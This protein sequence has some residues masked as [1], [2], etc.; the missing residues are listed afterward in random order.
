MRMT[1]Y[2]FS[3]ASKTRLNELHPDLQ[4]VMNETLEIMDITIAVGF[5]DKA[6]Q[7]AAYASGNSKVQWPNGKHN[8]KP[9]L[10]V[11]VYP[12]VFGIKALMGTEAQITQIMSMF[13]CSKL[14]ANDYVL[15]ELYAMQRI[16]KGIARKHNIK[17]LWGGDWDNDGNIYDNGFNDLGHFEL[18]GATDD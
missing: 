8:R 7:D 12:C 4:L 3:E 2:F 11:D 15:K 1:K 17:I 5:R 10:A 18:K 13:Q 14:Q 16:I 9:S 6:A